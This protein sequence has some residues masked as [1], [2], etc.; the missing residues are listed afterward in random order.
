[1]ADQR[2]PAIRSGD[3]VFAALQSVLPKHLLTRVIYSVAR[4]ES[5]LVK[6][7]LL[8][9]F[10]SGYDVNM[11]EAVQSDPFAYRSF[12]EFFTRALKPEAR[13]V[14]GDRAVI[15]SPVD[16]ALSQ[17]GELEDNLLL[18]A[19]G[20]HYSLEE[21]LAGDAEAVN[22]Y[23]GGHFACIYLAPFNYHRIHM[24]CA[25][26][27]RSNV[28]VPGEL[29][30]V[31]AS[32]ARAV[33]RV[34]ARNERLICDFDTPHGRMAVILVG[35]LFVGSIET[36]HCGEVNPPPRRRKAAQTIAR[37]VG[38]NFAK[39]EELGRFNMGSTVVLLFQRDRIEWHAALAPETALQLGR[40][41]G[42]AR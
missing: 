40:A 29:F 7:A 5:P 14:E 22:A 42:R 16:G 27:V 37:G 4:S 2:V 18:Q 41:I 9:A 36:V 24:P 21:L 20:H 17:C 11:A 26:A 23:R 3:R 6:R 1:M 35:A 19:K 25:G 32:T 33:P 34:F 13:P 39:A 10:L 30:S 31:N 8:R 15:V 28:Y 12:N 38:R